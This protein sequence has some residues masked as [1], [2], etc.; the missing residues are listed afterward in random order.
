MSAV[1]NAE[2]D[3]SKTIPST[4][5]PSILAWVYAFSGVIG[6]AVMLVVLWSLADPGLAIYEKPESTPVGWLWQAITGSPSSFGTDILRY[7][8]VTV[9][10][11]SVLLL[12]PWMCVLGVVVGN[13]VFVL[14]SYSLQAVYLYPFLVLHTAL[15]SLPLKWVYDH[16]PESLINPCQ[17]QRIRQQ[18]AGKS[19]LVSFA[20]T[21]LVFWLC[22]LS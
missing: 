5:E 8:L 2:T 1:E 16:V 10:I 12:W 4:Q 17:M 9:T 18:E 7:L 14:A 22:V 11:L 6:S 20:V 3:T 19:F 15:F 13:T 21:A